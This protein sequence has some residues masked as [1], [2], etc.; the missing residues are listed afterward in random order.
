MENDLISRDY[1]MRMFSEPERHS[2]CGEEVIS[3][4]YRV[5]SVDA[6]RI[7][8]AYW[9]P[10]AWRVGGLRCSNCNYP[11]LQNVLFEHFMPAYCER[12]GA[13][14]DAEVPSS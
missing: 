12:C 10:D 5:P 4:L 7:I 8:H 14:M 11:S 3:R 9:K 1:A 6:A 2:L 13:K